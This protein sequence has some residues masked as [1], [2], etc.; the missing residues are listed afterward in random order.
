[1]GLFNFI[2]S[3]GKK[4][5]LVGEDEAPAPEDVKKELDSHSLGTEGVEVAVVEDKV[6]LSGVVEDQSV[7]E[8]A[9]VSVG[10]TLGISAVEATDLKVGETSEAPA[11]PIFHTVEKGDNLWRI[12]EAN[13]G[14]GNG[15]KYTVIFEANQP[16][17]THPDKIYPGQ[18]LRIPPIG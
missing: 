10:N 6:V 13:Y 17:L 3:A 12:A 1:M 5:G 16:M 14:D 2:K 7:W 15:A 4:L 11:E 8:K 18:V 9:I